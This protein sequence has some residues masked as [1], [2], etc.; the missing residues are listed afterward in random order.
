MPETE[1][2]I[3]RFEGFANGLDH[4]QCLAF[5]RAGTLWAGGE[6]GQVYRIDAT[7]KPELVATLGG[8]N[9]GIAFSP[10]DHA[11][12]VCNPSHGL[13]RVEPDGRHTVFA[14]GIKSPMVCPNYPV[15]DR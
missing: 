10:R 7:G 14:R 9:G 1:I 11:L 15:F 4:P 8:F 3:E 13:V 2:P 6:A 12:Y 5:D